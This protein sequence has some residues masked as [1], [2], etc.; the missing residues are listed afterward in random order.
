M[1]YKL[2]ANRNILE[3]AVVVCKPGA[4]AMTLSNFQLEII[5]DILISCSDLQDYIDNIND[6]SLDSDS[7]S[8][9]DSEKELNKINVNINN[10]NNWS[11]LLQVINAS[12]NSKYIIMQFQFDLACDNNY[13]IL[14]AYAYKC[15][16]RVCYQCLS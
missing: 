8:C 10:G 6:I 16:I 13:I 4:P 14:T 9:E 2:T 7:D 3:F 11:S 1:F 12:K 15:V 5:S